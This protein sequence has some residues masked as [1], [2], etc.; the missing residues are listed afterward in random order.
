LVKKMNNPN[1]IGGAD[2][3]AAGDPTALSLAPRT[4]WTDMSG[5]EHFVQ[6]YET[7]LFLLDSLSSFMAI[8]LGE[9]DAC[10]VVAT[11]SHRDSLHERLKTYGL[12]LDAAVAC[13]QYV[14]LDAAETLSKLMVDGSPDPW[15]FAQVIGSIIARAA[16]GRRQVR[17]FGEMVALLWAEGN[18]AAAIS[19]EGLWNNLHETQSFLLFCAYPMKGFCGE[20]VAD[21]FANVCTSHSRVIPSESYTSLADPDER[22]RAI[23]QLQQKAESLE[24]EVA[25]RKKAEDALRAVKH[26]LEIQVEDLR[27]L[28]EMS[29]SLATMLD[30]ESVLKEVLRAALTVQETDLGLL[31]LCDPSSD[32]LS[33]KVHSGFDEEF[34]RQVEWVPAGLGSCGTCFQQRRRV[35]IEDVECDPIFAPYR[36]AAKAAG[37]RAVHSTPLIT[38]RGNI[39]GVLSVHFRRRHVPSEREIRL[40]DLYAQMAADTI[41]NAQLHYQAQQELAEREKLLA[42]EQRARAEAEAA[43]RMKDEFLATVSHEL[44]TPLN[45]IIGWS[46]LLSGSGIDAATMA[47][48]V[49]TIQRN[50]KSQA[51]LIEDI[52]DVSRVITGKLRLNT[53]L[54]NLASVI[55]EA[56]DSVQL[57]ANSKGIQ[58][59][60][61]IDPAAG[62]ISGDAGRLEQVT[63]NLL[64]NAIKFTPAGGRVTVRLER[65]SSEAQITVSDTG[66]GISPEFLPFIFDRFRQADGSITRLHGGLGLGLAIVRHLVELHGGTVQADS[67]GEGLGATFTIRL[68]LATQP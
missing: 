11:K 62:Q 42:R 56:I 18:Q 1:S 15:C 59:E 14:A 20:A 8:G 28:H 66:C 52:L 5:P 57:A 64:S 68:P 40:M 13:G 23:L 67:P 45:A 29:V 30:I 58:L 43:N 48:A 63:W 17:I 12:D 22:L 44:R 46:H 36:E 6:F 55:N 41:E 37:F 3:P 51:Q 19:L 9:G 32:G 10:I 47:R 16:R 2:R 50:A 31:S 24:A 26:E 34:L 21:A 39:I 35:V 65:A 27:R 60:L 4:D 33:A 49:E 53:G 61:T 54:V 25:E 7:D 38:R